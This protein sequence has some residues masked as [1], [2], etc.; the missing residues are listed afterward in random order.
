MSI[1]LSSICRTGAAGR[2]QNIILNIALQRSVGVSC[3]LLL[4]QDI[5]NI[6]TAI[7]RLYLIF[8]FVIANLSKQ[9]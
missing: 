5:R 3:P 4:L 1:L 2:I 6:C 8:S 7:K 9:V